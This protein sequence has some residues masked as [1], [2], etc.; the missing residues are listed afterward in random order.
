MGKWC[1]N[2]WYYSLYYRWVMLLNMAY[3]MPTFYFLRWLQECWLYWMIVCKRVKCSVCFLNVSVSYVAYHGVFNAQFLLSSVTSR[4]L[5][6][7]NDCSRVKCVCILSVRRVMLLTMACS[8]PYIYILRW[9][10]ECWRCWMIIG[11]WNV[12]FVFW[13]F[14]ELCL[15][16]VL[17]TKGYMTCVVEICGD[18]I[19]ISDVIIQHLRRWPLNF[20]RYSCTLLQWIENK[21]VPLTYDTLPGFKSKIMSWLDFELVFD[22]NVLSIKCFKY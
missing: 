2:C 18:V 10:Q 9:L 7:Q 8:I 15:W 4:I 6:M 20:L 16:W 17:L 5:A 21:S 11:A 22:P 13:I 14:G 19:I 12:A 1:L 3:S